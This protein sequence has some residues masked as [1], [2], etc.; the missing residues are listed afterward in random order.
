MNYCRFSTFWQRYKDQY[1]L[2]PDAGQKCVY[3]FDKQTQNNLSYRFFL[4]DDTLNHAMPL[5]FSGNHVS[6]MIQSQI[7]WRALFDKNKSPELLAEKTE[8]GISIR[9]TRPS[10]L[11]IPIGDF[12][13]LRFFPEEKEFV[14]NMEES[15][16]IQ[17][18]DDAPLEKDFL[19]KWGESGRQFLEQYRESH[20]F[21]F[22][23]NRIVSLLLY[24]PLLPIPPACELPFGSVENAEIP[25]Q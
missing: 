20:I 9:D 1:D 17:D 7:Y 4:E 10:L 18:C 8:G 16:M 21:E 22:L 25:Q 11:K 23:D 2:E 13:L 24:A 3:P 12:M 5:I 15:A 14:L 19:A 6:E